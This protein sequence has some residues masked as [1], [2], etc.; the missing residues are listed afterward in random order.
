LNK[1]SPEQAAE[2]LG[3]ACRKS[4]AALVGIV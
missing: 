3:A 2:K 4:L 1:T